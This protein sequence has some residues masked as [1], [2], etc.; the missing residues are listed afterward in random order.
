MWIQVRR[1]TEKETKR[2]E[3]EHVKDWRVFFLS[4][5]LES[6]SVGDS[7]AFYMKN[8]KTPLNIF[9]ER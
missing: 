8:R 6:Y 9:S 4:L 2:E 1:R 7:L 5:W 3:G